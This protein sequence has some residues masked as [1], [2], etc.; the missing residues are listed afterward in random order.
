MFFLDLC[1]EKDSN[2]TNKLI[3]K[4]SFMVKLA[5]QNLYLLYYLPSLVWTNS[6]VLRIP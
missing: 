4:I 5:F 6:C 1:S 3:F 2:I